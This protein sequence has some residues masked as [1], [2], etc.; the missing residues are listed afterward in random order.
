MKVA[1][2]DSG[3]GCLFLLA[4]ISLCCLGICIGMWLDCPYIKNLGIM[5]GGFVGS[6]VGSNYINVKKKKT[7]AWQWVVFFILIL[8]IT[9]LLTVFLESNGR[10]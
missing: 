8:I 2:Q 3:K 6:F 7:P 5:M 9:A 4:G 1:K 10:K